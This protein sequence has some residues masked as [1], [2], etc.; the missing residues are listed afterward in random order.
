MLRNLLLSLALLLTANA[1]VLAQS[2]GSLQG[3]VIDV[4][5]NNEPM[6]FVNIIVKKGGVQ[7]GGTTSDFDGKYVIKP[8]DPGEYTL[9]ATYVGYNPVKL[10]NIIISPSQVRFLDVEME[11]GSLKLDEVEIKGTAAP[12]IDKDQTTNKV[13]H[14]AKDIAKMPSRDVSAIAASAGGVVADNGKAGSVRGGSAS[15]YYVD[16]V[17]ISGTAKLPQSALAQMDVMISGL[18]AQYGDVGGSVVSV[19]TKGPSRTFNGGIGLET[20][21]FLDRFGSNRLDFSLSGPLLKGKDKSSGTSIIGFATSGDI[22]Y[23]SDGFPL[24][25]ELYHIKDAKLAELEENP[26]RIVPVGSSTATKYNAEFLRASDLEKVRYNDD[27]EDYSL[28]HVLNLRARVSKTINVTLGTRLYLSKGRSFNYGNTLMNTAKNAVYENNSFTAIGKWVQIFPNSKDS[29]SLFKSFYYSLQFD[30]RRTWGKTYDPDHKEDIFKYGYYG[31]YLTHKTATFAP[32]GDFEYNGKVY[33]D[34]S[35]LNSWDYD[36]L[37]SYTPMGTNNAIMEMVSDYY[38]L[39]DGLPNNH[40]QSISDLTLN[41]APING[42]SSSNLNA[43]GLYNLP[44]VTTAGYSKNLSEQYTA[45]ANGAVTIG[46][47]EFKFGFEYRQNIYRNFSVS[48]TPLWSQ[49]RGLTNEHIKQLDLDNPYF[50]EYNDTIRFRRKFDGASQAQFSKSLREML[51]L[52][53]SGIDFILT[54]SYDIDNNTMNYYDADGNLKEATLNGDL[55]LGMFSADELINGGGNKAYVGYYGYNYDGTSQS[56]N[57][58]LDDFLNEKDENGNYTRPIAAF[59]PTYFA[60]YVQDKFTFDDLIFNIGV[61]VD[62]YDANQKVPVDPYIIYPYRTAGDLR[63]DMASNGAITQGFEGLVIPDNISDNSAVYVNSGLNPSSVTGFREG[64]TWYDANG[65]ETQD[66][67]SLDAGSG[68]QPFLTQKKGEEK[69]VAESFKDYE[70][71]IQVMPRISFSFPISDEAV[72]SA[73]YDVYTQRPGDNVFAPLTYLNANSYSYMANPALT[74]EKTIDYSLTFQQVLSENSVLKIEGYY[75]EFRDQI[76]YFNLVGAYPKSY[77]TS[78][79]LNN[80]TAKGL[81][82]TFDQRRVNNLKMTV[83]YSL[84]FASR[85]QS[86][87]GDNNSLI[88]AGIPYLRNAFPTSQDRRHNI[89]IT[90][91]YRY[92]Q[93]KDYN[94]PVW[95]KKNGKP[96]NILENTGIAL[97]FNGGSGFPYSRS[98]N[99]VPDP[100]VFQTEA[101]LSGSINGSRHPWSFWVNARVDKDFY[102]KK[103]GKKGTSYM[104]VYLEVENL[105]NSENITDVYSYTGNPDDDGVLAAPEWQ[106]SI[107]TQTDEQSFRDLYSIYINKPYYYARPRTIK[108][109]LIYNF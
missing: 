21:Q 108:L 19:T 54:D 90:F 58:T 76:S 95:N 48:G 63:A 45:N 32:K 25:N 41:G 67:N 47:H 42:S 83:N 7:A 29:K 57:P 101:L 102:F 1:M 28:N 9:E 84:M 72:F 55:N 105:L 23:L 61:R 70:A 79:N 4:K 65:V 86:D 35:V 2:Q 89:G 97:S 103:E 98:R 49:M 69:M 109:G 8:L 39:Y 96:T 104:N 16:G 68:I 64:T 31:K 74:P 6:P 51:G 88:A 93:G 46:D 81:I 43:Y 15:V 10:G 92:G 78:V 73:H 17:R 22:T 99:V 56:G 75:R 87:V 85:T 53:P 13:T 27:A 82:F 40:Y 106:K 52:N 77:T 44:G 36:T 37:V 38:D 60:A 11:S 62:R 107:S 50:N 20:S 12:L 24:Y 66:P 33:E 100:A 94:G 30:Y 18:P 91:D 14:T 71:D 34:V 26:Y 59:R 80:G 5:A 3:E